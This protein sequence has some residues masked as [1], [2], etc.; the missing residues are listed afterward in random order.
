MTV[1][2]WDTNTT[3][4]VGNTAKLTTFFENFM[5]SPMYNFD[6]FIYVELLFLW[7]TVL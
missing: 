7:Y 6:F 4:A 3:I 2:R 5:K 1:D